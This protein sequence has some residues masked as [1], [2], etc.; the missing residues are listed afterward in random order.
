[1]DS[2]EPRLE[3]NPEEFFKITYPSSALKRALERINEKLCGVSNQ[4]GILL[5]GPYGSGKTHV[6][7]SLFHAFK[8]PKISKRWLRE[9]GVDL[10]ISDSA[11]SVIISTRRYD[12]DLLW[13]PIFTLLGRKDILSEIRRFP[14]VDQIEE[15]IGNSVCAIFIDEIENWYGSFNPQTQADLIEDHKD[16]WGKNRYPFRVKIEFIPSLITTEDKPIPLSS[17]FG[18]VDINGDIRI[19]PYLKNV[20]ITRI[21]KKQYQRLRN[22]FASGT[23]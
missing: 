17:L 7:I 5:V 14:T 3:N 4:G 22:L 23:N 2:R 12:V 21:S 8:C 19:E 10:D 13:E 9:W 15:V 6:L 1:V 20:C 16:V 11:K 18:K